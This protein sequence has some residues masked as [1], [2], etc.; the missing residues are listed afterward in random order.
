MSSAP[1]PGS[2]LKAVL[3]AASGSITVGLTPYLVRLV[4]TDGLDTRSLLFWRYVF[5]LTILIPLAMPKL[6]RLESA[7]ARALAGLWLSGMWGAMQA[8]AYYRSIETVATSIV[9]TIFFAYPI[10]TLLLD[11]FVL[12]VHVPRSTVIAIGAIFTG[13][14]MTSLPQ[15]QGGGA[16][17]E[18]LLLAASTPILYAIYITFSYAL[19]SKVPAFVAGAFIYV[20]QLT[21]FGAMGILAGI[22]SPSS[23]REWLLV[24]AIGTLGGALQIASFAYALPRLSGSG[25]AVIVSL[26]LVTV[27]LVG[28][29]VIGERLEPVQVLGVSLVVAGVLLDRLMRAWTRRTT[30]VRR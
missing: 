5:G 11:R 10:F 19:T 13:I 1:G 7:N 26:E 30:P 20:G 15:M 2:E 27:I 23:T 14:V 6:H 28:V 18:G 29:F 9:V 12:K 22:N 21:V 3:V 16:A 8:F 4:Q 24:F 25:Y 17:T